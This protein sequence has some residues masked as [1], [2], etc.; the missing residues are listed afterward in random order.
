[1]STTINKITK[2]EHA[3]WLKKIIESLKLGGIWCA[4]MGFSFQ[5]T[6]KNEIT[7]ISNTES[8]SVI[9]TIKRTK[10]IAEIAGIKCI[11]KNITNPHQAEKGRGVE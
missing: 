3:V 6:G 5:K 2:L 9:R 11:I 10:E 7:L 1:M 8:K 4:P